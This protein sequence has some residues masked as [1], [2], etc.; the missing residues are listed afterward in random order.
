VST[1]ETNMNATVTSINPLM[2]R[3]DGASTATPA[4]SL[5]TIFVMAGQRVTVAVRNPRP[6]II[7]GGEQ[8]PDAPAGGSTYPAGESLIGKVTLEANGDIVFANIPSEPYNWRAFRLVV[9]AHTTG[10][11]GNLAIR[12][13]GISTSSI[14]PMSWTEA[15]GTTVTHASNSLNYFFAGRL[16]TSF[17]GMLATVTIDPLQTWPAMQARATT[18]VGNDR[19]TVVASGGINSAIN[20]ITDIHLFAT[21]GFQLG[22]GSTAH[23]FGTTR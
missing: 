15:V 2:V 21:A 17:R 12:L 14:Y 3:V 18:R 20:P 16:S 8:T 22:T 7:V 11:S 13:N 23:L 19:N 6:P 5:N 10:T 1:T 4:D 9:S